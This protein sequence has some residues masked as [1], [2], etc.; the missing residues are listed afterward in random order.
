VGRACRGSLIWQLWRVELPRE[1]GGR[2]FQDVVGPPEVPDLT[3]KLG[4]PLL[5]GGG[6]TRPGG[7]ADLGLTDPAPQRFAVNAQLF[8]D[9]D[10]LVVDIR[11][12][13]SRAK[14]PQ[15]ADDDEYAVVG[16]SAGRRPAWWKACASDA[17]RKSAIRTLSSFGPIRSR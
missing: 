8:C 1:E 4:D 12:R 13:R 7:R 15:A 3:L 11:R 2:R 10:V 14:Q 9:P 17:L 5:V 6:G 16:T